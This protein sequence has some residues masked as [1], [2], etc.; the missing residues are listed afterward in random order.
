MINGWITK[1]VTGLKNDSILQLTKGG[2]S[3][4]LCTQFYIQLIFKAPFC[5]TLTISDQKIMSGSLVFQYF[6]S[7]KKYK[8]FFM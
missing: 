7:K 1:K 3:I 2:N 6:E 5:I 4:M 8:S